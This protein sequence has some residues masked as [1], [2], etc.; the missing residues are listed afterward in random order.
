[1]SPAWTWVRSSSSDSSSKPS[2]AVTFVKAQA[3]LEF[4]PLVE[5]VDDV[6]VCPSTYYQPPDANWGVCDLD[7]CMKPVVDGMIKMP[8]ISGSQRD[9]VQPWVD[10]DPPSPRRCHLQHRQSSSDERKRLGRDART[11]DLAKFTTR[12]GCAS[13][14]SARRRPFV[15]GSRAGR[16]RSRGSR[17]DR[18]ASR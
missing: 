3:I 12:A 9:V 11:A 2:P 1:M 15:A 4:H 17:R 16:S 7:F 13:S 5:S 6:C 14:S 10:P 8:R 18:R